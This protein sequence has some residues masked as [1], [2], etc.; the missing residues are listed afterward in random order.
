MI[1]SLG[2]IGLC[3]A[4]GPQQAGIAGATGQPQGRGVITAEGLLDGHPQRTGPLH[5]LRLGVVLQGA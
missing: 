5:D 1:E 4:S 2:S 3:D